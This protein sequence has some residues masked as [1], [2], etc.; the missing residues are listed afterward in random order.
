MCDCFKQ[1]EA[2][3]EAIYGADWVRI[4]GDGSTHV[5]VKPITLQGKPSKRTRHEAVEWNFCPICG[6]PWDSET[7]EAFKKY[8]KS[9]TIPNGQ[10]ITFSN[11]H[12]TR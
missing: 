2:A 6:E 4:H 9:R 5:M 11:F 7:L 8:Y 1:I 3:L 10:E 12:K